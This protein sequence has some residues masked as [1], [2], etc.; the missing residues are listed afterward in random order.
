MARKISLRIFVA[1]L[2]IQCCFVYCEE[3]EPAVR[4]VKDL[5][6][7]LDVIAGKS[8]TYTLKAEFS[9]GGTTGNISVGRAAERDY[10]V[11]VKAGREVEGFLSV[12]PGETRLEVAP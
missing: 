7:L 11:S 3:A 4:L 2:L 5:S 10:W 6:P 1:V 8:E 12:T 9:A